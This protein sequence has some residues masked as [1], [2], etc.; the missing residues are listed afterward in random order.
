MAKIIVLFK[1]NWI[2][3]FK[4]MSLWS[5]TYWQSVFK[6]HHSDKHFSQSFLP[7]RWRQNQQIYRTIWNE[8]TSVSRYVTVCRAADRHESLDEVVDDL[9]V[10]DVLQ[11]QRCVQ[12]ARAQCLQHVVERRRHVVGTLVADVADHVDHLQ[13]AQQRYQ[14]ITR[15]VTFHVCL[16]VCLFVYSSNTFYSNTHT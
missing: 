14:R 7:T 2:S 13:H 12:L 3:Q 16:F 5:L 8:I 10:A 1:Q 15:P 11:Q 4:K 9:V 6:R